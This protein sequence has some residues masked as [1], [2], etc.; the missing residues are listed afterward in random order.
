MRESLTRFLVYLWIIGI[1]EGRQ[2]GRYTIY[3]TNQLILC[4]IKGKSLNL[5]TGK[6]DLLKLVSVCIDL[7]IFF[8]TEPILLII[9]LQST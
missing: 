2:T 6:I 1:Q 8:F 9:D 5:F 3:C 7:R 4:V